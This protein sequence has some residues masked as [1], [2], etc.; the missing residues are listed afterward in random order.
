LTSPDPPPRST[1]SQVLAIFGG[2]GLAGVLHVVASVAVILVGQMTNPEGA[3][4][5]LFLWATLGL[6]QWI[7]LAPAALLARLVG[8]TGVMKGLL[9]AGAIVT[10]MSA[11]CWGTMML[12]GVIGSH[13][14]PAR[15]PRPPR[16]PRP[17]RSP[18][19]PSPSPTADEA[20]FLLPPSLQEVPWRVASLPPCSRS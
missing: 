10:L 4:V 5:V 14:T 15:S 13:A 19:P 1:G 18:R 12:G 16:S 6:S 8:W 11:M 2:L 3:L 17:V 7:Y 9:L 20:L